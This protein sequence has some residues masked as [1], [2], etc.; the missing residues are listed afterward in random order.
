MRCAM[1]ACSGAGRAACTRGIERTQVGAK[2]LERQR[3]RDVQRV[4]RRHGIMDDQR[5]TADGRRVGADQRE[6]VLR[7][8]RDRRK[9][10]A[11]QR[12]RARQDV[13]L[14]LGF[15]FAEQRQREMR[16]RREIGDADRAD[17][18]HARM[19]ARVQQCDQRVEHRGRNTRAAHR[20]G[21]GTREHHRAHDVRRKRAA[22]RPR[23]GRAP[24]EAGSRTARPARS[25][26]RCSRR[27]PN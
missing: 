11:S 22:R 16:K 15:A 2:P 17:R 13:A 21:S 5:R 1:I 7:G 23:R 25:A 8:E 6:S 12:F 10:G 3:G 27:A 9:A 19:H 24:H 20:H 26:D 4:E 14:E 18:R